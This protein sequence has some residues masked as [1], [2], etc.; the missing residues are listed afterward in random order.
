MIFDD[1]LVNGKQTDISIHNLSRVLSQNNRNRGLK[2]SVWT[3]SIDIIMLLIS[4]IWIW[5]YRRIINA[6]AIAFDNL[7]ENGDCSR[8]NGWS[9]CRLYSHHFTT[10]LLL[11][12]GNA[13]PLYGPQRGR[14][15]QLLNNRRRTRTNLQW[16]DEWSYG[17]DENKREDMPLWGQKD[18]KN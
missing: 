6:T 1:S 16:E 9:Q 3:W 11:S 15:W 7:T 10:P 2:N 13:N 17:K 8:V 14:E 18:P 4:H 12:G 5:W